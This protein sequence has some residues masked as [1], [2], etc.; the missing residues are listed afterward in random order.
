VNA[1][2]IMT[3]FGMSMRQAKE[4]Y[5]Q[6]KREKRLIIGSGKDLTR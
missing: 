4:L 2:R 1:D 6:E 5:Q 3:V